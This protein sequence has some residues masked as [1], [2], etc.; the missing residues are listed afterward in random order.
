MKRRTRLVAS[1]IGVALSS[2]LA[3][4][5]TAR[6]SNSTNGASTHDAGQS[7]TL[8]A[9]VRDPVG[10]SMPQSRAGAS[11]PDLQTGTLDVAGGNLSITISFVPGTLSPETGLIV[12]L[13]TDED[14]RT[15]VV[16]LR[17]SSP[18]GAD[19]VIRGLSPHDSSKASIT[20]ETAPNQSSFGGTIDVT[21]PV[22]NQ[23]RIV[24]PLTRLGNDDG[25]LKYKVE[26]YQV[27]AESRVGQ[28]VTG[29]IISHIDAMPDNGARPGTVR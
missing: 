11:M 17:E 26:C 4:S 23:R 16:A 18:I 7:V 8:S 29:T 15:G 20:Q 27:V 5:L 22:Q 19:Y 24:V 13:D 28:T 12:Y 6:T 14:A 21:S 1:I 2:W 25:R 10:D 9:T 3:A